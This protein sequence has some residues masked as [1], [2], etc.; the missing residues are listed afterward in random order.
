MTMQVD[1]TPGWKAVFACSVANPSIWIPPQ[2]TGNYRPTLVWSISR[3]ACDFLPEVIRGQVDGRYQYRNTLVVSVY[4]SNVR[5][6]L[7]PKTVAEQLV[8]PNRSASKLVCRC[9]WEP[10]TKELVC[11]FGLSRAFH[12]VYSR[13]QLWP[14]SPLGLLPRG[15]SQRS[16]HTILRSSV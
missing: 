16:H 12:H 13:D 10:A 9:H 1:T 3:F 14:R 4:A 7:S 6:R 15:A 8:S 2:G 5:Q 11:E